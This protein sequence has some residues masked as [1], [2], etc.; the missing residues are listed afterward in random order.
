M[1][2]FVYNKNLHFENPA[3]RGIDL[4]TY[5]S[6]NKILFSVNSGLS[7]GEY[8]QVSNVF[9]GVTPTEGYY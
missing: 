3:S 1:L 5:N 2:S 7:G 9:G 6:D 8:V 4:N